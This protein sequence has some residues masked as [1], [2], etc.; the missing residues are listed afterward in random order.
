MRKF[1]VI[2]VM[3]V[4]GACLWG[5]RLPQTSVNLYAEY[6]GNQPEE[7]TVSL[8]TF[9]PGSLEYELY[10]HAGIKVSNAAGKGI[11]FNYGIFDFDSPNFVYRFVK[12]ETDYMVKGYS[13]D[14][15]LRGYSRRK[16]VEQVLDL[17]QE[18]AWRALDYLEENAKPCNATYR[19]NYVLDNC[20]TRPRDIIELATGGTLEYPAMPDTMTFRKMMHRY[21][22]NYAW[23]RFGIDMALGTGLDREIT[24][25]E[26]MF[27]P[28]VLMDACA[29]ATFVRDGE[30]VPLVRE[31]KILIAGDEQ[32]DILPPTKWWAT[33][34]CVFSILL[35][36]VVLFTWR[37]VRR[38]RVTRWWDTVMYGMMTL[39]GV[40]LFF[41]IFVSTHEATSPNWNGVWM[42]PFYIIPAV[43]IWIKSAKRLLY[44]YHFVNFAVLFALLIAWYW[45]PQVANVAIFPLI[46]CSLVRSA[47]YILIYRKQK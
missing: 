36:V 17:S 5:Q 18:Q 13:T 33:P 4:W 28:M 29:G 26:Q 44:C 46:L 25:R 9:F 47:N 12:G 2:M 30:R 23:S 11:F 41:L 39:Y 27:V 7:I 22:A 32:G 3:L 8:V 37:D 1:I 19:Y 14:Y 24:Y 38:G 15:M 45:I 10:G 34:L 40:L 6:P 43:L 16:V 20:S 35:L 42:N 21:N 31:T